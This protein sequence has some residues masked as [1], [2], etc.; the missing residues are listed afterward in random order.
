MLTLWL[1]IATIVTALLSIALGWVMLSYI[2]RS[3]NQASHWRNRRRAGR[4]TLNLGIVTGLFLTCSVALC[5]SSLLSAAMEADAD[6][7]EAFTFPTSVPSPTIVVPPGID[8]STP[9]PFATPE[10]KDVLS[11]TPIVAVTTFEAIASPS[12]TFS[13]ENTLPP[14]LAVESV[15]T[16]TI[17][18]A[19]TEISLL[20]S[21]TFIRVN[22]LD[23]A[24]GDDWRAVAPATTFEEG[25]KR[26]YL[27][28]EY[29]DVAPGEVWE[30]TLLR[31][32]VVM[33][34][35]TDK[36]GVTE[37]AGETFF[38]FGQQEG[39]SAGNYEIRVTQNGVVLASMLF[40]VEP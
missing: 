22:A 26:I 20:T 35:Q 28:F 2:V 3:R 4:Q 30:R 32:G 27:Y 10:V 23:T 5:V 7:P 1:A 40:V 12:V 34:Q 24:I 13:G 39:F 14:S 25:V 6:E 29:A 11:E 8:L 17:T 37:P 19:P 21:T 9:D 33:M 31:D 16:Y 36:W 15:P 38:F 18:P